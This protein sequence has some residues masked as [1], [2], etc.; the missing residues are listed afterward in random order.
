VPVDRRN[1]AP[2][3][4][5]ALVLLGSGIN[6]RPC[7]AET[8][9]EALA[10][11]L[12]S[13]PSLEAQKEQLAANRESI[14]IAR[15]GFFPRATL[16]ATTGR[17]PVLNATTPVPV[18]ANAAFTGLDQASSGYAVAL[19]Q[20]LFDGFRTLNALD[21]AN[22]SVAAAEEDLRTVQQRILLDAVK[23][24]ASVLGDRA[25]LALRK[26]QAGMLK[27]DLTAT[28]TLAQHGQA[29]RTDI[30]QTT[31][32][33]AVA[34]ASLA[35]AES[36]LAASEA[37]F[38]Q[39]VGHPPQALSQPVLPDAA[40]PHSLPDAKVMALRGNPEILATRH[41]ER[42]ARST[43][44][45]VD[46]D[47]LPQA[48]LSASYGRT[49][50]NPPLVTDTG[51]AQVTVQVTLPISI[52]GESLAR[53]RQA[54]LILRQRSREV[55]AKR[56]EVVAQLAAAWA[57]LSAAHQQTEL[58][59]TA[60]AASERALQGVRR[61]REAGDKTALDVLNSEQDLIETKLREIKSRTDLLVSAYSVLAGAG[62]VRVD[63]GQVAAAP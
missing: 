55:T 49:Y 58:S 54:R 59:H 10:A 37:A 61:Q 53:S 18:P 5:T 47:F 34:G 14:A 39:I 23:A 30:D 52:G 33:L 11:T 32:R 1:R 2:L 50:S 13:N 15:A 31:A 21:E 45:K 17:G 62:A 36:S 19:E 35:A 7:A 40:V 42:A 22:E 51:D 63:A 8:L 43:I 20:P 48:N 16:S 57:A 25:T 27:A 24:Y 56:A 4:I 44:G 60:S 26:D 6:L 3:L 29:T 9:G 41:R 28:K 12:E 38:E 46:A